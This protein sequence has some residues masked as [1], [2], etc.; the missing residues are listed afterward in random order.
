[1]VLLLKE[2]HDAVVE[3]GRGQTGEDMNL[4]V[5][6]SESKAREALEAPC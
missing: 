4:E 6:P 1:M 2:P 5:Q 3:S